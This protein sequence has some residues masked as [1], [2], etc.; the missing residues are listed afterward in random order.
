MHIEKKNSTY[1][2]GSELI[3]A[4]R[5]WEV[6]IMINRVMKTSAQ[7]SVEVKK[8]HVVL[9]IIGKGLGNKTENTEYIYLE[10]CIFNLHI[11]R[12]MLI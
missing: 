2:M 3:V 7:S 8:K 9:G 1:K 11:S 12:M 10:N 6:G 4:N 5:L